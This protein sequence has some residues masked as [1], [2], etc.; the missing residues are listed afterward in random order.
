MEETI[1]LM[2]QVDHLSGEEIGWAMSSLDMEGVY[3]RNI[4]PTLTKKGRMGY[5]L[6]LEI[7]PAREDKIGTFLLETLNTHGY[8]KIN[9]AHVHYETI[10]REF[11]VILEHEK[12]SVRTK[13]RIKTRNESPGLYFVE[14]DDLFDIEKVVFEK[15]G[16]HIALKK[17]RQLIENGIETR[18]N[19]PI[20][21][22]F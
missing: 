18:G 3:N 14:S 2:A 5:I 22:Q 15:F 8:H 16:F 11:P 19:E 9:T 13:V 6:L 4:I 21:I 7:D 1:F 12:E 10:T 20:R 17:L